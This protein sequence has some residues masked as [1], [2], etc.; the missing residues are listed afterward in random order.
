MK[1]RILIFL[2]SYRGYWDI[3]QGEVLV[4]LDFMNLELGNRCL[5][6]KVKEMWLIA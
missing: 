2:K 6:R 3:R 1:S 4:M 5:W